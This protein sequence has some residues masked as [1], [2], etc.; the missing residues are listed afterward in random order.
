MASFDGD[1]LLSV[2]DRITP[3]NPNNIIVTMSAEGESDSQIRFVVGES[4]EAGDVAAIF[5]ADS[6]SGMTAYGK[7][8]GL[9]SSIRYVDKVA[10]EEVGVSLRGDNAVTIRFNGTPLD[11]LMLHD[12]LTGN[13]TQLYDGMEY[14]V[15]GSVAGRLFIIPAASDVDSVIALSDFSLEIDG[16]RLTLTAPAGTGNLAMQV[17]DTEGRVITN[18]ISDSDRVDTTLMPGTYIISAITDL[19]ATFS[20]KILIRL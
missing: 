10:R 14:V 12:A 8:E 18:V 3:Q 4:S 1:N 16:A 20:T 6:R 7:S 17:F 2:N 11:G 19:G 13:D 9:A 15:E 5:N